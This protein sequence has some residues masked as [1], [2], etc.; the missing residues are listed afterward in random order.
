MAKKLVRITTVPL[1]LCYLLPGQMLYM[2]QH[3]L[4]VVMISAD[5]NERATVIEN[6]GCRHIVVPMERKISIIKDIKCLIQLIKILK[7]EKPDI[8]H[9][10]TPKAGLLGMISAKICRVPLRI[11]T[12]AGLRYMTEA[13]IKR[14]ILIMM[15]KITSLAA[16]K[17][18]A[19][20]ISM[21]KILEKKNICRKEKLEVIGAGSTNGIDLHRFSPANINELELEKIKQKIKY[22]KSLFYFLYIGRLVKDKGIEE[23]IAAFESLS[24]E[25]DTVRLLLVGPVEN[26]DNPVNKDTIEK[27]NKSKTI[28]HVG[29]QSNIEYYF[30]LAN[31][32]VFPSHREGFPNVLLQAGAMGCPVLCSNIPGNIDIIN[33]N[34]TGILFTVADSNQLYALMKQYSNK[35][36]QSE[37]LKYAQTLAQHVRENYSRQAIHKLIFDK[38]LYYLA[39]F[40]NKKINE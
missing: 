21:K 34:K 14:F 2:K 22:S 19:N 4:D 18:W 16:N 23:L 8:V 25:N 15:E 36:Q 9:T 30:A 24:K 13:G 11:H 31:I 12:V 17:V 5:G 6:E 28:Q 7:R 32:F 10:H 37:L 35:A 26:D 39:N 3:G 38:Y 20:S 29:W 27:I 1:A 40:K 33:H